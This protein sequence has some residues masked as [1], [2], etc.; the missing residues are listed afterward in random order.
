MARA[1]RSSYPIAYVKGYIFQ[2][3]MYPL[4]FTIIPPSFLNARMVFVHGTKGGVPYPL[5]LEDI[6]ESN[7]RKLIHHISGYR[8]VK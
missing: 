4:S 2:G 8:Q 3:I 6:K 5:K 1:V 7:L